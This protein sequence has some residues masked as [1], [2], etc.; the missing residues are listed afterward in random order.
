MPERVALVTGGAHGIG[1]A[2]ALALAADG[3]RVAVGDLLEPADPGDLLAVLLDVADSASVAAAVDTVER[4]LGPVDVLVN[5]AGW[6]E[7]RPFLESDEPFWDRV[8]EVNF[9]GGLR[10]ARRIVPGMVERGWGRVVNIGSDAGRVGSSLES[11]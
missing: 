4:E 10:T 5:N 2:I 8:I 9:K 11:V 3:R 1:R 6:D 7:M